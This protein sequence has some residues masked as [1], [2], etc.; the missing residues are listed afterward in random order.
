MRD[1]QAEELS[2]NPLKTSEKQ[3][4]RADSPIETDKKGEVELSE[5]DLNNVSGGAKMAP[6]NSLK[7][8]E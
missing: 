1:H 2:K 4:S 7:V 5:A 8:P 3:P 6:P